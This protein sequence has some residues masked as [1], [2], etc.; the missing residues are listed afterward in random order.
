MKSAEKG[1][2]PPLIFQNTISIVRNF[3]AVSYDDLFVDP[4]TSLKSENQVTSISLVNI[5]LEIFRLS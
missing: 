5:W 3:H 4:E 2:S 1:Y